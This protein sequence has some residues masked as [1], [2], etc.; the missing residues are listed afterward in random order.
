[1]HPAQ[2]LTRRAP[3]HF[4]FSLRPLR[5]PRG[6]AGAYRP[7]VVGGIFPSQG[8]SRVAVVMVP[9]LAL[10]DLAFGWGG[11]L[12]ALLCMLACIRAALKS[13]TE[14]PVWLALAV[15]AAGLGVGLLV[16]GPPLGARLH[17]GPLSVAELGFLVFG[18]AAAA[19]HFAWPEIRHSGWRVQG[20]LLDTV[21]VVVSAALW[22]ASGFP[23]L[24]SVA[25]PNVLGALVHVALLAV[26]LVTALLVLP[27]LAVSH[28]RAGNTLA[29]VMTGVVIAGFLGSHELGA[30]RAFDVASAAVQAGALVLLAAVALDH[31]PS[32]APTFPT[33]GTLA[34]PSLSIPGLI[35]IS[36]LLAAVTAQE[37]PPAA[38]IGILVIALC[39]REALHVLVR[40]QA[41]EQLEAS[42]ELEQ[43][44]LAMQAKIRPDA[45]AADVLHESCCL[46]TEALRADVALAWIA[47]ADVLVLRGISP[48][49]RD[50]LL[51]RRLTIGDP[52]ALAARV[53]RSGAPEILDLR[54]PGARADRLLTMVLD[55]RVLLGVP[56]MR[57][58]TPTGVLVLVRR[59]HLS[60][61]Q[62]D[63]R[64]ALLIVAQ[65]EGA[66]RRLELDEELEQQ[67]RE[68]TLLHRFAV[69]AISARN[70]NDVGWYLLESVRSRV[71]FDRGAVFLADGARGSLTPVAHFRTPSQGRG[72]TGGPEP[73]QIRVALHYAEATI[74]YA[75]LTRESGEPFTP[76]DKV[77]AE[78]LAQ[79]AAVAIQNVRLQEVS[80]K[81]STL[82]EL[83]RL[84][85]DL[86]NTVSHDLRA[87]LAN[88]KGYASTLV[89]SAAD[90]PADE[91]HDYLVTIE[92]EADR[93]RDLLEHLLDL[94]K[95]EAGVLTLDLQPV[96][97]AR[98]VRKAIDGVSSPLH[99]LEHRVP[100]ELFVLADER[101]LRQVLHNLLENAVKYSPGGGPVRILVDSPEAEVVVSVLDNGLGIPRHQ[102]DRVFRPYQRADTAK[103]SGISG[104]GLGLAICKGIVEA[105]GGRI[106]VESEPEQGTRFAFSV[107]RAF[108][109]GD[110]GT[111]LVRRHANS[112]N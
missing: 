3:G 59:G 21:T 24:G 16:P 23:L 79:Q 106:W 9:M 2:L 5:R 6:H 61:S 101:R 46:A 110:E 62:F 102:W 81:V 42:L 72:A 56:I 74:G 65:V 99:S 88:I 43:Q 45:A 105:H 96:Q 8:T 54:A 93:L 14:R 20:I 83:D 80:G 70:I 98:V 17:V 11:L 32:G 7:L 100:D 104:T 34:W 69:Q 66:L 89:D 57:E 86:L 47:D 111:T 51:S 71:P 94:S 103:N 90:M 36:A 85:T 76:N 44:L 97:L 18:T 64:R 107:M 35:G 78:R 52:D 53:F 77:V 38:L 19:A 15:A 10:A 37:T 40:R 41:H 55:A 67:L 49:R 63:L 75:D 29:I 60:F 95:I 13:D 91:Q 92:E 108:E 68:T 31:R 73:A 84:K 48:E 112:L 27:H 26:P 22:G 12:G 28:R 4:P 33:S 58:G 1:M 30:T 82:K 50:T 109:T 25:G 87:P 39:V